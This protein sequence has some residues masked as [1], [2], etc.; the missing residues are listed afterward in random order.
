[1]EINRYWAMPNKWT[2]KIKPIAELL[3]KYVGNGKGWVDCFAGKSKLA[4]WRNDINPEMKQPSQMDAEEFLLSVPDNFYENALFDPPYTLRQINEAY[5]GVGRDLGDIKVNCQFYSRVKDALAKKVKVG[6]Y[7]IHFGY[8]SN[9]M[10]KCRGFK[11]VE[12]LLIAH[13]GA[14]YD[15]IV[16]VEKKIQANLGDDNAN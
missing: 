1:M 4:Q 11:I 9:G 2:F 5:K 16:T 13:G 14:H 10:G 15:T 3:V 12:I 6:G 7:V 8:H